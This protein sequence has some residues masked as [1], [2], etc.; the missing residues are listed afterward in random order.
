MEP[1]LGRR[2]P[3]PPVGLAAAT[4]FVIL[5]VLVVRLG[6]L[7]IDAPVIAAVQGL[8]LARDLWVVITSLGGATVLLPVGIALGLGALFSG[9]MR[10]TLIVA[11]VLLGGVL[12]T[13]VL[14]AEIARP[15]PIALHLVNAGGFSFPSGHSLNSAATY[16]LLAVVA[17]R[18][19]VPAL[20]RWGAVA[21][22]LAL[23]IA[24]GLS[25]I[26]L[27]VHYPSDV[28]GGW[29]AALALVASGATAITLFG[30]MNRDRPGRPGA[31][32]TGPPASSIPELEPEPV[33]ADS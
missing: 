16:G 30:A 12:L 19:R 3:W 20:L 6:G 25:R 18:S 10:L 13:E 33:V 15:R 29:L 7:P 8:G 24:I 11:V 28:L 2:D 26:A 5:T 1:S 21:I 31:R 22:G 17:L 14:K 4:A 23:P 27:G 32:S 9:R